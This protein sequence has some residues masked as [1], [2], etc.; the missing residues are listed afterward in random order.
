MDTRLIFRDYDDSIKT[1]GETQDQV[2][3]AQWLQTAGKIRFASLKVFFCDV[4][5]LDPSLAPLVLSVVFGDAFFP[6]K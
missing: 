5:L 4:V 3:C 1:D 2:C 6:E